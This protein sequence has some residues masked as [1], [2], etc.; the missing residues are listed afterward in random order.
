MLP[1]Q[2][3]ALWS[4][5]AAAAGS[6]LQLIPLFHLSYPGTDDKMAKS[7]VQTQTI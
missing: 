5:A 1:V 6:E 7:L 2:K 3:F 4:A